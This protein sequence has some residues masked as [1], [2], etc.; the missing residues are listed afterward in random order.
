MRSGTE[1]LQSAGVEDAGT[2]AWLLLSEVFGISRARYFMDM[3]QTCDP[4]LA[5]KYFSF[6]DR[7]CERIPLQH[8]LGKAPFMEYEFEVN[9]HVLTPRADT[10]VLVEQAF[11]ELRRLWRRRKTESS[12]QL[13][14]MC[15]GSGCIAISLAAMAKE[16]VIPCQVTGVDLSEDALSVAAHNNDSICDGNV[17]FIRS[18]LFEALPEHTQFDIIV[19]NPPYIRSDE[20]EGLMPEVRD[21]EPRMALDGRED[22]LYFYREIIRNSRAYLKK[23][24]LLLFEIGYD[25]GISVPEIM[26]SQ[27]FTEVAVIQD[28]AGLD[29]VVTG[30]LC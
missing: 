15:T 6:I 26:K 23:G 24:G 10:E 8:I 22:G 9:E 29:R 30:K 28:L 13:L 5:E 2:D 7:R 18:N 11:E 4:E 3:N 21:H 20:I 27:G 1:R 25:Q 17:H 12:L 14:D 19:S 16:A